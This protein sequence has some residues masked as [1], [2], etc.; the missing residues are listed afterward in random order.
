LLD[1]G[2]LH[3]ASHAWL[4][5]THGLAAHIKLADGDLALLEVAGLRL[6][7]ALV[8][9]SACDGAVAD[10]LQGEEV[11]SLSWALLAAGA[12]A[13]LASFFALDDSAV[14]RFMG[15]FYDALRQHQDAAAALA[16]AQRALI[17]GYPEGVPED[18]RLWGSFVL[19]GERRFDW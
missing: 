1:Y 14:L 6:N 16:F 19:I 5:P 2:L 4:V 13:V 17:G 3:L 15:V 9:L 10:I 8:T 7:S 18:P 11:L 12:S